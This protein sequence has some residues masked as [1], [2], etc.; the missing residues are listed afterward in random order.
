MTFDKD[1]RDFIKKSIGLGI[2]IYGVTHF[3]PITSIAE[4]KNSKSTVV[5]ARDK[6]V[7]SNDFKIDL[8]IVKNMLNDA[9]IKLSGKK[10]AS[11]A[12]KEYFRSDDVVGIKVNTLSGRWMSSSPELVAAIVEGLKL[13]GIPEKNM[14]IWDKAD[15]ELVEAGFK[16]NRKS[17]SEPRCFGTNPSIGYESDVKV[18][19]SIASRLSRIV[20][21]CTAFVNVPVLKHH[22]MAGVTI[23]LKNWFGA[24][25]NPNKYHFAT[26]DSKKMVAQC[27]YIPDVNFML[28]SSSGLAKRQPLIICD[29]IIAQYDMGP[30]YNPGRAWNYSGLLVSDDPVALDSVGARI[31]EKKRQEVGI[32][33]L[34]ESGVKPEYISFAADRTHKLGI[35]NLSQINL[36]SVGN[37]A[38]DI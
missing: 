24:I 30:G 6:N 15:R 4:A 28:F 38:P 37:L 1:R 34:L 7:I 32:K 27:D 3:S 33:S 19:G 21:Y 36:I 25:N 5:I 12:W 2:G 22:T 16:I 10:T 18:F 35:N 31:I 29:A 11:G 9:I 20:P 13:V 26:G 17:L 8:K 23:S 14:V